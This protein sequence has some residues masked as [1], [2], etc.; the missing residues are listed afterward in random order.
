MSLL[1]VLGLPAALV[2]FWLFRSA[3]R[4]L[5]G[6][7]NPAGRPLV[8]GY[9]LA[10]LGL[11]VSLVAGAFVTFAIWSELSANGDW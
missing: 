1:P 2:A 10:W 9:V 3:R 4:N 7:W 6:S 11:A 8:I 5:A